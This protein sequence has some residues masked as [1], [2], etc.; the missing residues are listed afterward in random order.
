MTQALALLG[1][2]WLQATLWAAPHQ[3]DSLF[4]ELAQRWMARHEVSTPAGWRPLLDQHFARLELGIFDVYVPLDALQ[5]RK[6]WKDARAGLLAL[7]D[8]QSGMSAWAEGN[9]PKQGAAGPLTKWLQRLSPKRLEGVTAT[10]RD[11]GGPA[12][13]DDEVR[14]ALAALKA[15]QRGG[16]AL[17]VERELAGVPLVIFPRRAAFVEFTC[18]AGLLDERLKPS[19]WSQG[20]TT[21]LEYRADTVRFVT[22]EYA[23]SEDGRDFERGISVGARNASALGQL[24]VQVATRAL[25]DNLFSA[26]LDPAL[27]S[28]LANALVIDLYDELDTRVDGDVRSRSSQGSSIFVPGGNPNGGV[29]PATSA[30]N[31]WRG[32]QG[33][34]HFANVLARVQ[35]RSGKRGANKAEKFARF[36]LISDDGSGKWK[37]SAPFLGPQAVAPSAEFLP[38]Y[39]EL[40]RCYGVA[41]LHWL[42]VE[43]AGEE[44]GARYGALLRRLGEGVKTAELPGVFRE[45]YGQPLSAVDADGLFDGETLEGRFL[46]WL[47]KQG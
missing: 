2:V 42:R 38:D 27:S 33:K 9:E 32:T 39:L 20:L 29:L 23:A 4:D 3:D 6:A 11:M 18:V 1:A 26:G 7:L 12:V 16:A 14:Q 37:A 46:L 34:D 44:S 41:F 25:F 8:L 47:S 36:E 10:E 30:E 21:W 5:D 24:V 35:K 13:A 28:G 45:L 17:G 40:I 22:L 19:A 31:R 15:T 43:G